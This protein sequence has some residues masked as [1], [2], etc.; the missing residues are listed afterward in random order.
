MAILSF[1]WM[2]WALFMIEYSSSRLIMK[3]KLLTDAKRVRRHNSSFKLVA[4]DIKDRLYSLCGTIAITLW[5][6]HPYFKGNN[7]FFYC[8]TQEWIIFI[9]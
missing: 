2:K 3:N 8:P 6:M 1:E 5:L 7:E 4:L 9:N